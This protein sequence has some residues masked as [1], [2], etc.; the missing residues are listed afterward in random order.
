MRTFSA[1]AAA[2]LLA[3]ALPAFAQSGYDTGTGKSSGTTTNSG[4]ARPDTGPQGAGGKV[5]NPSGSAK[6]TTSSSGASGERGARS[7]AKPVKM[8]DGKT[9]PTNRKRGTSTQTDD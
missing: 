3:S 4:S 8:P 7:D 5:E 6:P 2:C 1:A 9:E